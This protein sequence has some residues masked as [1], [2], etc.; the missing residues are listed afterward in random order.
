[1]MY[2]ASNKNWAEKVS[3]ELPMLFISGED[4]P[5]GQMGKGIPAIVDDLEKRKFINIA[6]KQYRGM[7]H[8]ILQED[9]HEKVY[10]DILQWLVQH[11]KR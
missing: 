4:D 9:D 10:D 5:V 3:P 6:A 2:E 8:E 1:M 7:R 11:I